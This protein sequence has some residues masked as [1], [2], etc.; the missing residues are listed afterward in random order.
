MDRIGGV[1]LPSFFRIHALRLTSEPLRR[2][3]HSQPP[4]NWTVHPAKLTFVYAYTQQLK[5]PGRAMAVN[6]PI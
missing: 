6:L 2:D 1:Q 5:L 3:W 4:G